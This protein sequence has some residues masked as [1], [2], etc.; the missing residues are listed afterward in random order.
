MNRRA[1]IAGLPIVAAV[2]LRRAQSPAPAVVQAVSP[3]RAV[4]PATAPAGAMA[5]SSTLQL[6][7]EMKAVNDEVLK[8]QLATL[9]QLEE[10]EKSAEQIKIYTKRG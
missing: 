9:Q 6:L 10:I 4:G 8:K 5:P 2:S 7:Q 1:I 3:P